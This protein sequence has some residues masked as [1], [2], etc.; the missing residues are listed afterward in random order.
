MGPKLPQQITVELLAVG[1]EALVG[2]LPVKLDEPSRRAMGSGRDKTDRK[3][4]EIFFSD[5]F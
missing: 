5:S 2:G 3:R 1:G 4:A